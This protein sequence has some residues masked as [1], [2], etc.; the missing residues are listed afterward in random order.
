MQLIKP[1]NLLLLSGFIWLVAFVSIPAKYV[2]L[3]GSLWFPIFSLL[4]F[5]LFFVFGLYSVKKKYY[6]PRLYSKNKKQTIIFLMAFIGTLGI[7]VRIYQRV[8]V[9]QI[10]FAENFIKTRMELMAG[11]ANSGLMGVFSAVT[12]PF[13]TVALMLAILWYKSLNKL[14]LII[15]FVLGLFPVYDSFLTQSRLLIVLIF[16]LLFFTIVSAKISFF[17]R[18]TIIKIY[19]YKIF[20]M[21]SVLLKKKVMIPTVILI[22]GFVIFSQK[23]MNNRLSA[24]AYSDTLSVWEFYHESEIDEEFKLEV[25]N[26]ESVIQKNKLIATYSLKHYF[27]H[28]VAEYIRLI[29]HLE[30]SWGY[31]YGVFELYVYVKILKIL[32]LPIASFSQLNE[33]SYKEAVYTTFWGPFYIDFGIFGFFISFLLGRMVK[34]IYLKAKQGSEIDILFYAFIATVI[35][36]SFFVNFA[37]SGN[38]YFLTAIIGAGLLIYF[39]PN[40]LFYT[41]S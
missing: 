8:F 13:A 38:L 23:V 32:G 22:F 28:S 12:Y 31:Y 30:K 39:W 6:E 33:V 15:L 34:R 36:A 4:A 1:F 11:E 3:G 17:K 41:E 19:N 37:M 40:K 18:H 29:N 26:A 21:P 14:T 2:N 35:L 20:K 16:G 7:I 25:N 5:N 27:A 24:F 10:Y 9:E